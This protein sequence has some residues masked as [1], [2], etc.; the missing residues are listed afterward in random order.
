MWWF[1]ETWKP[2]MAEPPPLLHDLRGAAEAMAG[3][4]LGNPN[5]ALGKRQI[6]SRECRKGDIFIALAGENADGHSFV[7]N[8]L[9]NGAFAA[10]VGRRFWKARGEE[11]G[12]RFPERG[13]IVV[14]DPLKAL[15]LWA[16]K[17]VERELSGVLRIGITGSSGKTTTKEL[18]GAI[19][20][21][22]RPTAINPGNLNSDIGLPLAALDIPRKSHFAVLEMGINRFGEMDELV[23]IFR[24]QVGLVTYIGTAHLGAFGSQE[25]IARE[26]R[27]IF[28]YLTPPGGAFIWEGETFRELLTEGLSAPVFSYGEGMAYFGGAQN[29]GFNGWTLTLGGWKMKLPLMGRHNLANALGAAAAARWLGAPWEAVEAGFARQRPLFARGEVFQGGV[30]LIV[31]CYNANPESFRR[32]I[33]TFVSLPWQGRRIL[34]AGAMAELGDKSEEAHRALGTYITAQPLDGVFYLGADGRRAF[35][36]TR[37]EGRPIFWTEDYEELEEMVMNFVRP[38]DLFY[39]K[40]SRLMGLER[41]VKPLR[42]LYA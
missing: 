38:G 5:M 4:P 30:S 17:Y 12:Q 41:L 25:A 40:G 20:A 15:Q 14:E 32:G 10:L 24:P 2:M 36:S 19:L 8:A 31:D 21:N 27:K 37:P 28:R 42:S 33:E 11:L 6:D 16:K 39:L 13:F 26:K 29:E 18:L 7:E 3:L 9:E 34:V 22:Y 35:E 23:E 1:P